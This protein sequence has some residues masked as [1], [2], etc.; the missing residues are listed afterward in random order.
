MRPSAII[1]APSR[2]RSSS[3][4]TA[5]RRHKA[6]GVPASPRTP[7]IPLNAP[8]SSETLVI[9]AGKIRNGAAPF[10]ALRRILSERPN[11]KPGSVLNDDLSR[12]HVAMQLQPPPGARRARIAPIWALLLVGFTEPR[13]SPSALVRSYRTFPP[14]PVRGTGSLFLLHYP[15]GHPRLPLAVTIPLWSPDFPQSAKAPRRRMFCSFGQVIITRFSPLWQEKSGGGVFL[16]S[17]VHFCT[18]LMR[19]Y[20]FSD[21]RVYFRPRHLI[22]HRKMSAH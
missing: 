5:A 17:A 18:F 15:W 1:S 9:F 14:F 7:G 16:R 6:A 4:R 11:R 2:W 19:F 3:G 22:F 20:T 21:A 13:K 10:R 12:L 8:E